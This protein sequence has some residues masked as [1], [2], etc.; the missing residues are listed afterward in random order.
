MRIL[1]CFIIFVSVIGYAISKLAESPWP[2]LGHDNQRSGRS[3]IAAPSSAPKH[4]WTAELPYSFSY[5]EPTI[6]V[7]GTLY[8]TSLEDVVTAI[9]PAGQILYNT[10][11]SPKYF[12]AAPTEA[13]AVSADGHLYTGG[14]PFIYAVKQDSGALAW[15]CE[16]PGDSSMTH[17]VALTG[18]GALLLTSTKAASLAALSL[19][20]PTKCVVQW[21]HSYGA[22]RSEAQIG[23]SIPTCSR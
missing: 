13:V 16:L 17:S 18:N 8:V 19:S 23:V 14:F 1:I 11:A 15:Q 7:D 10:P 2:S 12:T 22:V 20:D 5:S 3:P 21:S 4:L 9:S 6:A